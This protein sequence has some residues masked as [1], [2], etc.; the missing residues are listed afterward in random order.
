MV[1]TSCRNIWMDFKW[2]KI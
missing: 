1:P 2:Y